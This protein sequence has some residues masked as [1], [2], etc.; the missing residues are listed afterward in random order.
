MAQI[1][2][3]P[4]TGRKRIIFYQE[5]VMDMNI[6]DAEVHAMAREL[7]ARRSTTVTDAVLQALRAELARTSGMQRAHAVESRKATIREICAR[8]HARPEWLGQSGRELQDALYE[9]QGLPK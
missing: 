7:A 1:P 2:L 8:F 5:P 9:E 3:D 6:K 4:W